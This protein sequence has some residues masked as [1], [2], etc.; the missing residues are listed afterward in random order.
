MKDMVLD[1]ATLIWLFV[2]IVIA[3]LLAERLERV[4]VPHA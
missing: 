3:I 4:F 2:V 1:A